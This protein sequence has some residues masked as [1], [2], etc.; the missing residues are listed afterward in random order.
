MIRKEILFLLVLP[1]IIIFS[2]PVY[3]ALTDNFDGTV[4]QIK[5]DRTSLMW[6][7]NA[8]L[9]QTETFGVTGIE[10]SGAMTWDTAMAW[11]DAMNAVNYLGYSNWRL[12]K[13]PV[14][15][16]G[17][18]ATSS[19]MGYLYYT[20]LGNTPGR[21]Y[22]ASYFDHVEASLY[23]SATQAPN[24]SGAWT[25]GFGDGYQIDNGKSLL[26]FAWAVRNVASVPEPASMLLLGISLVGLAGVGRKKS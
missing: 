18:N 1:I 16:Y 9:A 5:I 6:M 10:S 26:I 23:W 20:E 13:T 19:E 4:T 14:V 7:E 3:A 2:R 24:P 25:F 12:P 15:E 22:N 17:F 21:P 8:N 11:I